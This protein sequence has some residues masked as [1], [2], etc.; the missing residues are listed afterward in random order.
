MDTAMPLYGVNEEVL[1]TIGQIQKGAAPASKGSQ[2]TRRQLKKLPEWD[3]WRNA[4]WAQLDEMVRCNMLGKVVMRWEIEGE[5]DVFCIVWSYNK[6]LYTGKLKAQF[7]G[8]GKPLKPKTKMEH[9]TFAACASHT[10]M[11]ITIGTAAF[12]GRLLYAADAVNA[13]A[14][15]GPLEKPCYVV[16]DDAF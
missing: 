5:F 10:G 2:Y 4:E 6:K 7:C 14:Q 9:K 11:R 1:P 8:N 13:F 16:V 12:E 15:S 3:Q